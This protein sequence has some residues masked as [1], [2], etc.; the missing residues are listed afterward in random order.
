MTPRSYIYQLLEEK[1]EAEPEQLPAAGGRGGVGVAG[2]HA[3]P[4]VREGAE[5]EQV[6]QRGR[7]LSPGS[8]V[9]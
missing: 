9:R 1:L 3:A 2:L 6:A 4:A 8:Q 7:G 5:C